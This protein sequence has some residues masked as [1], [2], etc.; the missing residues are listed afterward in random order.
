MADES[1]E[2]EELPDEEPGGDQ[3]AA[4]PVKGACTV[5]VGGD[6]VVIFTPTPPKG[7]IRVRVCHETHVKTMFA[8]DH[9]TAAMMVGER[10]ADFAVVHDEFLL[11]GVAAPRPKA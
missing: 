9:T 7:R 2:D 8:V 1:R 4:E 6:E 5:L 3:P 11:L 10:W